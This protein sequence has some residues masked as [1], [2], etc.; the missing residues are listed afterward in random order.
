MDRREFLRNS[1]A[2]LLGLGAY[3]TQSAWAFD[4][5]RQL[6]LAG[7]SEQ[8]LTR[9]AFGSCNQSLQ[10]QSYW[11]R[12]AES[13]PQLWIWLGDNIYGDGLSMGQRRRRY[14]RLKRDPYYQRFRSA[15]PIIGTWDDHDYAW[16]N[17][18]GSFEDK[19]ESK[20]QIMEFL[21]I[22]SDRIE[23]HS[24]IYQSYVF[25]PIGRRT[26]VILLDLRFNQDTARTEP[27][28][29]GEEQWQWLQAEL[30]SR[31]FELLVIGSSL[32][33]TAVANGGELEGWADFPGEHARLLGLLANLEQPVLFLS[34]DR[35]QAEFARWSLASGRYGYEFMS[36]GL[37]HYW[38]GSI[39]N[40]KRLGEAVVD[41][42][43]GVV[44]IDWSTQQ[45]TLTLQIRSPDSGLIIREIRGVNA[46]I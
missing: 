45:P 26:K 4:P 36:S 39:P 34:G 14:A 37:T 21:D 3:S 16:N 42:N 22:P 35:H 18:D 40:D 27:L 19:D 31:D 13:Q 33:L 11:D 10:S 8:A 15:V 44:E 1:G 30:A 7:S 20:R 6:Y 23:S 17:H 46:A 25:G 12:I 43:F 2:A 32:N 28:L 41:R 24:G 29:L 38:R 5:T 9:F